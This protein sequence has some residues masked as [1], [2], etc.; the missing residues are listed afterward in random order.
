MIKLEL[1]S[2]VADMAMNKCQELDSLLSGKKK[3]SC[4]HLERRLYT[5]HSPSFNIDME[6]H[7]ILEGEEQEL[8]SWKAN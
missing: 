1:H 7:C 8:Q 4:T 3:N 2:N 5:V 6:R